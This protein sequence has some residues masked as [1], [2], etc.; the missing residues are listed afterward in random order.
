MGACPETSWPLNSLCVDLSKDHA[1]GFFKRPHLPIPPATG[2]TGQTMGK[3]HDETSG[4]LW[5]R[6]L[7]ELLPDEDGVR[8][9][10]DS[11]VHSA[12]AR[13]GRANQPPCRISPKTA[14]SRLVAPRITDE[15]AAL[16]TR[17]AG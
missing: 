15:A 6:G 10:F 14:R 8:E 2:P 9:A 5:I 7:R 11:D 16:Y 4:A 13:E 1:Q 3:L 12:L 17:I